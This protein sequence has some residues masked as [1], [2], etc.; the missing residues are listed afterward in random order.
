MISASS[1]WVT[2]PNAVTVSIR[3]IPIR[4]WVIV[5]I[6]WAFLRDIRLRQIENILERMNL[7]QM[8]E[9]YQAAGLSPQ[10]TS[11]LYES[12]TNIGKEIHHLLKPAVDYAGGPETDAFQAAGAQ[13]V[14]TIVQEAQAHDLTG[15]ADFP[16]P[17]D[18]R[19]DF[20]RGQTVA[21]FNVNDF[22]TS[23]T[24]SSRPGTKPKRPSKT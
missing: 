11:E 13:A 1:I 4:Y 16:N 24:G 12:A 8:D 23:S 2:K 15:Y 18:A 10:Q 20:D 6:A 19:N 3:V 14:A 5:A 7:G 22:A 17:A 21:W 9:V